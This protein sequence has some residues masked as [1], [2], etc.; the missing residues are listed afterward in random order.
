MLRGA[1]QAATSAAGPSIA[2]VCHLPSDKF[3][4]LWSALQNLS[5]LKLLTD[6]KPDKKRWQSARLSH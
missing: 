6:K 2:S 5:F 4:H 1:K 3:V